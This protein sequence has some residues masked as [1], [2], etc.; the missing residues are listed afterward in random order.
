MALLVQREVAER[1]T[2]APGRRD[3]G[4]LSVL[5][6]LFS[7][8]RI[9]FT[10]PPGAFTP[11]PKVQSA[12]VHFRMSAR[13]PAWTTEERSRFLD[14]VKHCFAHKRKNL[15]NNLAGIYSRLKVL[16]VLESL[17]LPATVRAEQLTVEKFLGLFGKLWCRAS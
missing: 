14:F 8:P 13:F 1:L 12:L 7:E 17:E 5:T 2:A 6:Q 3:Y 10:V 11:P 15:L 16:R 4:Y 9:A